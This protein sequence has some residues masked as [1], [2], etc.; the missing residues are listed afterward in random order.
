MKQ[1]PGPDATITHDEESLLMSCPAQHS[2]VQSFPHRWC[3]LAGRTVLIAGMVPALFGGGPNV[4]V[5]TLIALA[6]LGLLMVVGARRA[7]RRAPKHSLGPVRAAVA[8]STDLLVLLIAAGLVA[9]AQ[10]GGGSGASLSFG[11]TVTVAAFLGLCTLHH[12]A[13]R[14][15]HR[16]ARRY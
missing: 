1:A 11:G 8:L 4:T 14:R 12:F 6:A 3:T 5:F 16:R 7:T 15:S 9:G 2:V 13:H 10:L